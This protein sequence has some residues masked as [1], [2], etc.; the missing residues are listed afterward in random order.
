MSRKDSGHSTEQRRS[1]LRRGGALIAGGVLMA[2]HRHLLAQ[3]GAADGPVVETSA[4]K[5]RGLRI[6]KVIAFKGI[7]YGGSTA[8]DAR[9]MPPGKPTPWPGVR[10]C[11]LVGERAPQGGQDIMFQT[12]PELQRAEPE[13][14]D[15]LRLNV[16]T[17]A[18]GA[19]KRP[20]M[21]WFH[22]GGY[23]TGSG[24]FVAYDGANLAHAED[25]VVVTL[26]HRLNVFGFLHVAGIG[27]SRYAQ[28]A[29]LGMQ[30]MVLA[31]QWVHDN[32]AQFGGD[33]ANV[34]I[35]GQS[36]G[37]GKVSTLLAMPAAKGLFHR[38]IIESGSTVRQS[39]ADEASAAAQKY[40]EFANVKSVDELQKLPMEQIRSQLFAQTARPFA[41][42]PPGPRGP[43]AP[44]LGPV[45]D[46]HWLPAQLSDAAALANWADIPLLVGSNETELTF[47]PGTPLDPI[48]EATLHAQI[49][50]IL[51]CDDAGA[52]SVVAAYRTARP[53]ATPLDILQILMAD[54]FFRRGTH[55]QVDLKVAQNRAPVYVYYF[56]WR[57]PVKDGKLKACHCLEIPFVMR[58]L[59]AMAPMVGTGAEQ[60]ALAEQISGAWA[61]FARSGKP[62]HRGL[63][64]WRAADANNKQ[65]L[66]INIH[67]E[68]V[69]DPDRAER[70]AIAA[71]S[72]P[73]AV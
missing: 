1:F 52:D 47:F 43:V 22:G 56:T 48:D 32:I 41:P 14:E 2:S 65:T 49:K 9:F 18:V 38:A 12:F 21:V 73:S 13:G 55:A 61:S 3:A 53:A 8:G 68:V 35:F 27:G 57:T 5:I 54:T 40:L 19:G 69:N 31:L 44:N 10:E 51:R 64:D 66:L 60:T 70:A 4:G 16:W 24:G 42:P 71:V 29:N 28:S 59:S 46:G 50:M 37:G 15:C 6:D 17:N 26:N 62:A 11:T 63:P 34:T 72:K 67:S 7:P 23:A 20:V 58:N 45:V 39:T 25:V 30:D 33:A 36:G